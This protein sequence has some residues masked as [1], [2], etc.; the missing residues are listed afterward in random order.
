MGRM[1]VLFALRAS[2]D[3]HQVQFLM[4]SFVRTFHKKRASFLDVS[5]GGHGGQ[6]RQKTI[7]CIARKKKAFPDLESVD[8]LSYSI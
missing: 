2:F 7:C 1:N 3:V 5:S 6:L 4:H 8:V